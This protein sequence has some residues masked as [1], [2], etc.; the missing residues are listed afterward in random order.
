MMRGKCYWC[1]LFLAM[2]LLTSCDDDDY[3]YPSVKLEFLTAYAGADG[4]L[5]SVLTDEGRTYTVFEDA[6]KTHIDANSSV[7]IVSNYG[8]ASN[9]TDGV[10]LY[11][12][13]NAISPT[14]KVAGDFKDGVKTDPASVLSIWMGLNYL[15]VILDIQAQNGKHL[16]HF[17]EEKV[18]TDA[19]TGHSDVHLM[20]Y[21]DDG[22]DVQAYSRRAYLSVPLQK[23][24]IEGVHTVSVHFSLHTYTGEI[25]TYDFDYNPSL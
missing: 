6:S 13:T 4:S 15:N 16:F 5:Q 22:N 2:A 11:N 9:G 20:L 25:K 7:R 14:P 12:A 3:Y 19:I 8:T 23:Y 10:K 18:V 17:I 24:A 21:H 1:F